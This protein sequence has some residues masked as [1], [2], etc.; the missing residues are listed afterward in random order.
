MK[1]R[2]KGRGP[3]R[4][5]WYSICSRHYDYDPDCNLCQCGSW[6]NVWARMIDH[7]IYN[8]A[9]WLWHWWHN[10]PN[11]RTRREHKK[12]FPNIK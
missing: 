12:W 1:L 8:H 10:R 3:F 5:E 9:Y 2:S 11:S 4:A 7:Q 6:H